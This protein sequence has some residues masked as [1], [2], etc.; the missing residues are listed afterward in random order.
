[1]PGSVYNMGGSRHS[2]IS[3]IEAIAFL[4]DKL[5]RSVAYSIDESKTRKGDHIW[6]ISDVSR[7]RKD[8]PNWSYR[9]GIHDI[10]SEMTEVALQ[11][12]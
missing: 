11:Q 9:Y 10:L 1:M 6:Y 3:M 2:N 7:F 5:G 12:H 4:E 8:Y